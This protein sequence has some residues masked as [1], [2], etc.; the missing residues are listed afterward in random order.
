MV[1]VAGGSQPPSS[2]TCWPLKGSSVSFQLQQALG[3][4]QSELGLL[5]RSLPP[6]CPRDLHQPRASTQG[7]ELCPHGQPGKSGL[8]SLPRS[9]GLVVSKWM[10]PP[11]S[12]AKGPE[13]RQRHVWFFYF[14]SKGSGREA[15][16]GW[17]CLLQRWAPTGRGLPLTGW[18]AS[19]LGPGKGP[20]T[21]F[22]ESRG[23][24][25]HR[26]WPCHQAARMSMSLLPSTLEK[27]N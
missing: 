23:P 22:R 19:R 5:T 4:S 1:E 7:P 18:R 14:Q 2:A 9:T 12:W 13:F 10:S 27:T 8:F 3:P 24:G 16:P 26:V 25:S 21:R 15:S 6:P 11:R 17:G 20:E